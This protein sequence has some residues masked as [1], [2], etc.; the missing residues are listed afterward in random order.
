MFF[1]RPAP[2]QNYIGFQYPEGQPEWWYQI[3][4]GLPDR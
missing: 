1:W 3:V 4:D 2:P